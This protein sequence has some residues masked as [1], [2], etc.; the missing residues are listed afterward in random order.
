MGHPIVD[1]IRG[2]ERGPTGDPI[3][4][5]PVR[6]GP[7]L[8]H[9]PCTAKQGGVIEQEQSPWSSSFVEPQD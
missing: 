7:R 8:A 1:P 4:S 3:G 9:H 5:G 6:G 2:S